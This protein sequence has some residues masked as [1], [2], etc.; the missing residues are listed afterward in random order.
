MRNRIW[1]ISLIVLG[2]L[3]FSGR[4]IV[5]QSPQR[6]PDVAQIEIGR[7]GFL[8]QHLT[9]AHGRIIMSVHNLTA[10]T[11]NLRLDRE[12]AGTLKTVSVSR[13]LPRWR[14]AIEFGPGEYLLKETGHPDWIC[15]LSITQ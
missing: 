4:P 8:P 3:A 1:V 13:D 5:S 15:R 14:E 7:R 12:T 10:L 11:L 2:L 6:G 9:H